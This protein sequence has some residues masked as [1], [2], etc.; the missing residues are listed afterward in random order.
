MPYVF[1]CVRVRTHT[2]H[3][4][5][6]MHSKNVKGVLFTPGEA[7]ALLF[8]PGGMAKRAGTYDSSPAA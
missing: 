4:H 1:L 8:T 7:P 3:H 2:H 5:H 6:H